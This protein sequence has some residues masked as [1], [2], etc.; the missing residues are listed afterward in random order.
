[1]IRRAEVGVTNLSQA[2]AFPKEGIGRNMKQKGSNA[3]F[4]RYDASK[5]VMQTPWQRK[6]W[7]TLH[8]PFKTPKIT[9]FFVRFAQ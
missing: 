3:C 7:S 4:M 6:F 5:V 1:M 9:S 2:E 8:H